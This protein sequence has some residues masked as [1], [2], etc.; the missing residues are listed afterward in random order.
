MKK[1]II[2]TEDRRFGSGVILVFSSQ[3][4]CLDYFRKVYP[5]KKNLRLRQSG[6][7]DTFTLLNHNTPVLPWDSDFREGELDPS[8]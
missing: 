3:K 6:W 2:Y 1:V 4:K 7:G 5:E 8:G